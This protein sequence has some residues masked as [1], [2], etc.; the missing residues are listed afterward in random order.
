MFGLGGGGIERGRAGSGRMV[1]LG[2]TRMEESIPLD[3][4]RVIACT[5]RGMDF[6]IPIFVPV[7]G[8]SSAPIL[9][10]GYQEII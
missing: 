8:H 3:Q 10:T 1:S 2:V 6:G 4:A 5:R 7:P 9:E